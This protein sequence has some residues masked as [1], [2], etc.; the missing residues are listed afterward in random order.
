MGTMKRETINSPTKVEEFFNKHGIT[1]TEEDEIY[2]A[3]W[4]RHVSVEVLE[5]LKGED[6]DRSVPEDYKN[7]ASEVAELYCYHGKYDCNLS[8]WQNLESLIGEVR[9]IA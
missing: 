3:L 5:L 8:Y 4:A 1:S 9:R 7:I 6:E 2:R